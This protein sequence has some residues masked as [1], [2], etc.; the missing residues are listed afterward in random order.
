MLFGNLF[1][2]TLLHDA[3]DLD[4]LLVYFTP[5]KTYEK[6]T[7]VLHNPFAPT[8]DI[9]AREAAHLLQQRLSRQS[10]LHPFF[11]QQE[12]KM[13]GVL[14]VADHFGR[15]AYLSAFSGM[16]NHQWLV[17]G[18]VPP[19]FN[20][21][22]MTQL[23]ANSEAQ[24]KQLTQDLAD[25]ESSEQRKKLTDDLAV[26]KIKSQQI[27]AQ[28]KKVHRC[29][30]QHRKAL[31]QQQK[32]VNTAKMLRQLSRQSQDDK[33]YYKGLK[34]TFEQQIKAL[35]NQL[36]CL[37]DKAI[38]DLKKQR[39][40]LSRQ[41]HQAVFHLYQLHNIHGKKVSMSDVF[42]GVRPPGGSGDCAAPK[43]IHFALKHRLNIISLGEFW[44]G[45]S[46]KK[47]IRHHQHF[48]PPCRSKC[49]HILPFMLNGLRIKTLPQ[50]TS[51]SPP[52]IVYE[53][54][55]LV[56]L[57]KPAGYLSIPGKEQSESVLTWVKNKYPKADGA[58]LVHRLDQATSGIL[59]VAKTA[60]VHKAL[61]KQ[62]I[63]RHIKKRYVAL[64][65][66]HLQQKEIHIDL[67][68]RVDLEDRPRQLVCFEHGKQAITRVELIRNE[69]D[70]SRVYLYPETGRT[71]QLR[72][73]AAH[74]SGLNNPIV[75]DTLYGTQASRLMLHAEQI[76]FFH[77]V[78]K[79]K[80]LFK[81]D[82]PF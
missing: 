67:P 74:V 8:P 15:V 58:L 5:S 42:V 59:L 4:H 21:Q 7:H 82:A 73:H 66:Q 32:G 13:F 37:F 3:D 1:S 78:L 52:R 34:K 22:D 9:Y 63:Q 50:T 29:N 65:T 48:Y 46:P 54:D 45:A 24:L 43:L 71:H 10:D 49:Q 30:K 68:L 40:Q 72:V 77:P 57:N 81:V 26:L 80:M 33:R 17:P 70:M 47:E 41:T 11:E 55:D 20:V 61:Q 51:Q 6:R 23:L 79:Q 35:E 36:W 19:V 75:G 62:F 12:G 76:V 56:A 16:L 38:N 28:I 53:D 14:V 27:L 64:L 60:T 39:K 44:W 31:R 69:G 2:V 25:L 18:F